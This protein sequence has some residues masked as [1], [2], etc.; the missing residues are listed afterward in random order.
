MY[1]SSVFFRN[2]T[3]SSKYKHRPNIHL[4][5]N[6]RYI[7][8]WNRASMNVS[9]HETSLTLPRFT[10]VSVPSQG[11]QRS[12]M[13][14]LGVPICFFLRFFNYS[15]FNGSDSVLFMSPDDEPKN[16]P[17]KLS[18]DQYIFQFVI[19]YIYKM[20]IRNWFGPVN[21]NFHFF[22]IEILT[23]VL[24]IQSYLFLSLNFSQRNSLYVLTIIYHEIIS[25]FPYSDGRCAIFTK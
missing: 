6:H 4:L 17:V 25:M 23:S 10:K 19:R 11:S 12:C 14:L 13:C 5:F 20:N 2:N 16:R 18:S 3:T 1:C 24:T 15:F 7:Y 22:F 8:F 9:D 21:S